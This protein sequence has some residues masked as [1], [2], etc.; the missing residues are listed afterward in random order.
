MQNADAANFYFFPLSHFKQLKEDLGDCLKLF[1]VH[2]E[3]ETYSA[4]LFFH[5]AGIASYYLSARNLNFPKVPA[6]NFLLSKAI[7]YYQ[8]GGSHLFNL[9]GGTAAGADN[10]L[11]K[12]KKNFSS[13]TT[14]FFIG[15]RVILPDVYEDIGDAYRKHA[16][17]NKRQANKHILQFYRES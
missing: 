13:T 14:P 12:F 10:P 6:G 11:L 2:K 4:A 5:S 9:G 3:Q 1:R 15:R 17:I 16:G 7:Q 8:D